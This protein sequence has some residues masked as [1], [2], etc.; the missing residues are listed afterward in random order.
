MVRRREAEVS[1]GGLG[2][3]R[4]QE[5]AR[6]PEIEERGLQKGLQRGLRQLEMFIVPT[7][8]Y[9]S[10]FVLKIAA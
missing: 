8:L 4:P 1:G 9:W 6:K 10:L 5:E 7:I 2:L 3:G